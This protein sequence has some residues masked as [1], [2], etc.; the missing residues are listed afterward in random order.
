MNEQIH[1]VIK[2]T[3]LN[4]NKRMGSVKVELGVNIA[5]L[6]YRLC[7]DRKWS[8]WKT[9]GIGLRYDERDLRIAEA[10]E[11]L[12]RVV[13]LESKWRERLRNAVV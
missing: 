3:G 4:P 11:D 6:Y 7:G 1:T 9:I 5:T 10:V 8:E 13:R 12:A 2:G